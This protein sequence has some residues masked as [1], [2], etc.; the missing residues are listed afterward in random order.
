MQALVLTLVILIQDFQVDCVPSKKI[1]AH[2]YC[3]IRCSEAWM[4]Q[5]LRLNGIPQCIRYKMFCDLAFMKI[6][7]LKTVENKIF[8]LS[9]GRHQVV[10]WEEAL[11]NV[12]IRTFLA[13]SHI[14]KPFPAQQRNVSLGWIRFAQVIHR[15]GQAELV[16]V[17]TWQYLSAKLWTEPKPNKEDWKDWENMKINVLKEV[18]ITHLCFSTSLYCST[19][20]LSQAEYLCPGS[21]N[22]KYIAIYLYYLSFVSEEQVGMLSKSFRV[23]KW[24]RE[25]E[26]GFSPLLSQEAE[27]VWGQEAIHCSCMPG[28]TCHW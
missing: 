11:W 4:W 13:F 6:K 18:E 10:K 5:C 12:E 24:W 3:K 16:Q 9:M 8:K 27:P 1:W 7:R 2:K 20:R 28:I 19:I 15:N 21:W 17:S 22:S 26:D 23:E 25:T 14:W